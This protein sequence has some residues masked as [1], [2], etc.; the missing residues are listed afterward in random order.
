MVFVGGYAVQNLLG[1][2][3]R[4]VDGYNLLVGSGLRAKVQPTNL[5]AAC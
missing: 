5:L 4:K 3:T 1:A 2:C